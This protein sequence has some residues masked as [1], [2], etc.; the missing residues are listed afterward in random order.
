LISGDSF[1]GPLFDI[2]IVQYNTRNN[3]T[4]DRTLV[5]FYILEKIGMAAIAQRGLQQQQVCQ[6]GGTRNTRKTINRQGFQQQQG[7]WQQ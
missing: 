1:C 7:H 3:D 4:S 5:C 2:L 6:L